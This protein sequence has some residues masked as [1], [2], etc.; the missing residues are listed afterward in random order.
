MQLP[1][2][3]SL[4]VLLAALFAAL[5]AQSLFGTS[6]RC[7]MTGEV[8]T[9]HCCAGHR[10]EACHAQVER[11]DCCELMRGEARPSVPA[12]R[13]AG[14]DAASV[15]LAATFA[16]A[17][18]PRAAVEALHSPPPVEPRPPGPARFLMKCSL[19]I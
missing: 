6:Y 1:C 5:P 12:T 11:P 14:Q 9:T 17:L 18:A 16:P 13:S 10:V 7:H 3:R 4:V 2:R 19:L 8:S 15:A